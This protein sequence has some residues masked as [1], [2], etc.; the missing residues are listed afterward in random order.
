MRRRTKEKRATAAPES[1]MGSSTVTMSR[2]P[3]IVNHVS[4]TEM[5]ELTNCLS[6]VVRS[7][8]NLLRMR[9]KGVVSKKEEG[10]CIT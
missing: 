4:P 3:T 5:K 2:C 6:W 9:P 8:V 1:V 7:P 10:Q